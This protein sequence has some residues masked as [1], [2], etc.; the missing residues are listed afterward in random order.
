MREVKQVSALGLNVSQKVQSQC[1]KAARFYR[2]GV[3]LQQV[4]HF[5]NNIGDE[6]IPSAKHRTIGRM[7]ENAAELPDDEWA[8]NTFGDALAFISKTGRQKD[9][10]RARGASALIQDSRHSKWI[11]GRPLASIHMGGPIAC[12][13]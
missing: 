2:A 11:D 5:Y 12:I 9:S 8:F 7:P 4:A 6:I 13:S 3:S 1:A 10:H